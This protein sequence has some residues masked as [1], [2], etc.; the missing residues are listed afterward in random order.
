MR[1]WGVKPGHLMGTQQPL[2]TLA[3]E[4]VVKI[5]GYFIFFFFFERVSTYDFRS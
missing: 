3:H 5:L 4:L 2:T 1:A